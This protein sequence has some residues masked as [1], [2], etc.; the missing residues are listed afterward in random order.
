[1]TNWTIAGAEAV[2]RVRVAIKNGTFERQCGGQPAVS[3]SR[4]TDPTIVACTPS[5]QQFPVRLERAEKR[6]R[7]GESFCA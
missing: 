2:L 6:L 1:M 4:L 3:K 7:G 5:T